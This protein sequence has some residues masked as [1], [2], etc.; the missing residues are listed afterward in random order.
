MQRVLVI[1]PRS[2]DQFVTRAEEAAAHSASEGQLQSTL[3]EQYPKALVRP[4]QISGES[5][6]VWYVYRDGRWISPEGVTEEHNGD[7]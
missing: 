5:E 7:Y 1:N 6:V 4:R 2:D 3:R